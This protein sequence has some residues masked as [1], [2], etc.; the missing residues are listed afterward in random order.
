MNVKCNFYNYSV[1]PVITVAEQDTMKMTADKNIV[2]KEMEEVEEMVLIILN[3]IANLADVEAT[4]EINIVVSIDTLTHAQDHKVLAITDIEEEIAE[5]EVL[6]IQSPADMIV[7]TKIVTIVKN[8]TD[9]VEVND[10]KDIK[11]AEMTETKENDRDREKDKERDKE[12]DLIEM[13]GILE[14]LGITE[15]YEMFEM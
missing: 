8:L 1:L 3:K 2:I 4:A 11:V 15:M 14:I 10:S 6:P 12:K 5:A 9:M 7:S 13:L